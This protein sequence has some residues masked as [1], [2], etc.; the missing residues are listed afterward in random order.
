ML[1]AYYPSVI[2]EYPIKGRPVMQNLHN[3]Y[4]IIYI[5]LSQ[6]D[7]WLEKNIAPISYDVMQVARTLSF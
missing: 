7:I 2:S 4:H 6:V 3:M 5:Y 1:Q